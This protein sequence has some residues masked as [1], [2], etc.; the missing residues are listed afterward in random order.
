MITKT[1]NNIDS[2]LSFNLYIY[3]FVKNQLNRIFFLL[4]KDQFIRL[5]VNL[6]LF[7]NM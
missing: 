6:N 7:I 2:F 3:K 5:S 1:N 4:S